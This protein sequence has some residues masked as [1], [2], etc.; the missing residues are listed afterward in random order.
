MPAASNQIGSA[1]FQSLSNKVT[2]RRNHHTTVADDRSSYLYIASS[3]ILDKTIDF[4]M[5][6]HKPSMLSQMKNN[7]IMLLQNGCS[8]KDMI[9][10]KDRI[11]GEINKISHLPK[12]KVVL[13]PPECVQLGWQDKK[14]SVGSGLDNP[15]VICYINSTLQALF[16]IP[17]FTNW[18]TNDE[19]HK[20][21]CQQK[22]GF[23]KDCI[24]CM[25]SDTFI[26]SQKHTGS[27]FK[28]SIITSRLSLICKHLSTYRQEDAHE[29]LRYLI[30]SMERCY[31]SVLG[32]AAKSLD[33]YSKET[34]PIN[35]IFGGYIRT[36]VTCGKCGY[37]STTFQHF[38]D[39]I[40]DIRQSDTVND[41]LDNY[42]E[43][44]PLDESYVCE[45]CRRQVVADKKFS[46]ERAPNVLCI[47]LKRYS[48]G[49]GGFSGNKNSK[50]IQIN[51]RL[52][53]SNYQFD[54]HKFK[55]DAR[56]LRYHLVSM[57]IHY[58][59]SLN[60]GHY[61]ALGL[62]PSGSYYYFNDSN[63]YQTNFK[64]Y[65]T[66][67][68]SYMIF[69]ELESLENTNNTNIE[70][71]A[72]TVTSSSCKT[73]NGFFSNKNN[74]V[75][76]QSNGVAKP[77]NGLTKPLN[78]IN[79][80]KKINGKEKKGNIYEKWDSNI[81]QLKQGQQK[82]KSVTETSWNS[83][84]KTVEPST[85][86]VKSLSMSN[87]LVP[88]IDSDKDGS[89]VDSSS[90]SGEETIPITLGKIKYTTDQKVPDKKPLVMRPKEDLTEQNSKETPAKKCLVL[91]PQ[92]DDSPINDKE[93]GILPN[94]KCLVLKPKD[95]E[96]PEVKTEYEPVKKCLV[97]FP[98][99]DKEFNASK[100]FSSAEGKDLERKNRRCENGVSESDKSIIRLEHNNYNGMKSPT[101]SKTNGKLLNGN[102]F[103][104][105]RTWNKL[106]NGNNHKHSNGTKNWP[107][108]NHEFQSIGNIKLTG[109]FKESMKS[110]TH[111]GFGGEVKTWNGEK[112]FLDREAEQDKINGVKRSFDDD[113]N[114]DFDRGVVKKKKFDK[115]N[116]GIKDNGS[117]ALQMLHNQLNQFNGK[118]GRSKITWMNRSKNYRS[119]NNGYRHNGNGG[120]GGYKKPRLY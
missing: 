89:D 86:G 107:K 116:H 96:S 73:T 60:S 93:I 104:E 66:S 119:Y 94:K 46:V 78:G 72:S 44:E 103:T 26:L 84:N 20:K 112:S 6:D 62:T 25:V 2:D 42:F 106:S 37:I 7:C 92:N 5:L 3:K 50:A 43:K 23:Q 65:S 56:P 77:L 57:V 61:T 18:L 64:N 68:D 58:G 34:T 27:S 33:N 81:K 101:E 117:N 19:Q 28:A 21:T 109:N 8:K 69:Y 38:Q 59:S 98:K 63:V 76:K 35:Q 100:V 24:V 120:S 49:M 51:E 90:L 47:Q 41:A 114:E 39:L 22:T 115:N 13:Y 29:F 12:P 105:E 16:H 87:S 97:R 82:E 53:L 40:L 74:G 70:Y 80:I 54:H 48:V 95:D 75:T 11:N 108:F 32:H 113:Y 15:G 99:D 10:K 88:Y 31:L 111:L 110:R 36:E 118:M 67:N 45:R 91:K 102:G 79:N 52:D 17:A 1:L 14:M 30:E 9:Q 4:E 55:T 71:K 85:N 83:T